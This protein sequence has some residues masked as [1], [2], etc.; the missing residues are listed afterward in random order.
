MRPWDWHLRSTPPAQPDPLDHLLG[1]L[2]SSERIKDPA[3]PSNR[4]TSS[5]QAWRQD[6]LLAQLRRH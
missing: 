2:A 5:S 6:Q 3:A 4:Q 1:C